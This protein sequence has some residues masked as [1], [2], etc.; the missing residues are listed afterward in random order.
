ML[1]VSTA[2]TGPEGAP[3]KSDASERELRELL[4]GVANN[5]QVALGRL[6]DLTVSRLFN[7]AQLILRNKSDA[8]E[9]V[10]DTYAQLWQTASRFDAA[11]GTVAGWLAT[12]CRSRAL[13]LWRKQRV[14]ERVSSGDREPDSSRLDNGPQELLEVVQQNTAVHRA[15][16]ALAPARRELI[17]L[18]FFRDLSHFQIAALTG[19]PV[20]T[21]KSHIRRALATL[22]AEL[23]KEGSHVA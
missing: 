11:R 17:G 7:V 21:V 16:A 18:A 2:E 5:D 22:H 20:G 12:I 23:D 8:E 13:D 1:N 10:V 4:T 9:V 6:Y 15:L 19:L 14:R 3:V